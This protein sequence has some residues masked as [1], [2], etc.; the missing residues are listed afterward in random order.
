MVFGADIRSNIA[1]RSEVIG[2]RRTPR[3]R[4]K[5]QNT[6]YCEV[7]WLNKYG[8]GPPGPE[9]STYAVHTL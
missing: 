6:E 3:K 9:L 2:T 1:R 5:P 8:S 4:H 7:Q